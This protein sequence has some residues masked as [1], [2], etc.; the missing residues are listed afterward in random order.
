[1]LSI[2]PTE[3]AWSLLAD[4][5]LNYH[6]ISCVVTALQ[7][8]QLLTN[9]S[10]IV[11]S[12]FAKSSNL[13]QRPKKYLIRLLAS[14]YFEW[15]VYFKVSQILVQ[16]DKPLALPI[17]SEMWG[18]KIVLI[19]EDLMNDPLVSSHIIQTC[20]VIYQEILPENLNI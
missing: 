19:L 3:S 17:T 12:N 4:Y 15:S 20:N 6:T 14:L 7:S 18:K 13:L 9:L 8:L 11:A 1:M 10:D 2:Q 5:L 16:E